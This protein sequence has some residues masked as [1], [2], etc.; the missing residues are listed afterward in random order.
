MSRVTGRLTLVALCLSTP[1]PVRTQAPPTSTLSRVELAADISFPEGVAYDAARGVIYTGSAVNG[2]I[3][4]VNLKTSASETVVAG[5]VLVPAD[6]TLF[7][8]ILGMK[9]DASNRLW[10]AG[11]RLGRMF[12]I[13]AATG[14]V[15]KQVEVPNPAGSL[16]NDV[17]LIGTTGYFTDTRAPTLWRLEARGAQ[18]GDLEPWLSFEKTVLEYNTQANLNGIVATPDGQSL[19]TVQMGKGL[20]FRIDVK[21]KA[22]SAIDLAGADLTGTDGLVLDGRTLYAVRQPAEEI[23]TVEL[24]AD[25]TRGTVTSRFK[26][27]ALAQPATAAKVDTRLL[28]VNTQFNMR[29]KKAETR[30]FT[31]LSVPL[32]ALAK[33]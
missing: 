16:I 11:G 4:R 33:K 14:R 6:S 29:T 27:A 24:S 23:A 21:T 25:W 31:I 2:A 13:D 5:G 17:A 28:V 8:T 20:L 22:V 26:D 32:A 1:V 19:I 3:S 30:P 15:L 9:L 18:I 7:P 12:V 10:V